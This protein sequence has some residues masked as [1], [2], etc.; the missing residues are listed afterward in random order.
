MALKETWEFGKRCACWG[1]FSVVRLSLASLYLQVRCIY[2]F[3]VSWL[4]GLGDRVL[5]S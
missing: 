4:H 3:V 1:Y 2:R 5:R